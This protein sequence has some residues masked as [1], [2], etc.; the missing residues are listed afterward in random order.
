[1][2]EIKTRIEVVSISE[3]VSIHFLY[4]PEGYKFKKIVME[5]H[6]TKLIGKLKQFNRI[7]ILSVWKKDNRDL[8]KLF[9]DVL[10]KKGWDFKEFPNPTAYVCQFI[11]EDFI[12]KSPN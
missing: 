2:S 4:V 7:K 5:H 12:K 11:K 10:E 3:E 9:T 6:K 8:V 1:M